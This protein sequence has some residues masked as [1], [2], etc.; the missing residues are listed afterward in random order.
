MISSNNN[1][2]Y[3]WGVSNK[4]F[5]PPDV[6]FAA[7]VIFENAMKLRFKWYFGTFYPLW[8]FLLMRP[9]GSNFV[10][11]WLSYRVEFEIPALYMV[12]DSSSINVSA[13]NY[14]KDRSINTIKFN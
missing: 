8:R 11:M 14:I 12:C 2:N 9:A 6:I 7:R 3:N 5:G 4:R 10:K 13:T 1:S